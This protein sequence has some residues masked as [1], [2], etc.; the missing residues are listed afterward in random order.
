MSPCIRQ[1]LQIADMG[2]PLML[3]YRQ[4]LA[5]HE[6]DSLFGVAVAFRMLQAA[7]RALSHRRLWDRQEIWV[8]SGHPGDGVRDAVE[9]VTRCVSRNR[10]RLEGGGSGCSRE[11]RFAWRVDHGCDTASLWLSEGFVPAELYELLDRIGSGSARLRDRV[12][13]AEL[14]RQLAE[15]VWR[16]PLSRLFRLECARVGANC[17]A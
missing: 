4:A 6:G 16:E 1:Q 10:Y 11:M 9:F 8:T 7:G 3:D 14:K 15:Q 17:R 12:R 5:A 13:F 2:M